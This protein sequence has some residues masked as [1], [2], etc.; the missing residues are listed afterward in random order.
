M[1][2]YNAWKKIP[3]RHVLNNGAILGQTKTLTQDYL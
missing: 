3:Y 2:Y 1:G